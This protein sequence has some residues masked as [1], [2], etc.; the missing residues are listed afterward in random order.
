MIAK[1][2]LFPW[3]ENRGWLQ[4]FSYKGGEFWIIVSWLAFNEWALKTSSCSWWK[5]V[6]DR[7]RKKKIKK[8]S[9]EPGWLRAFQKETVISHNH[10]TDYSAVKHIQK[11]V[12]GIRGLYFTPFDNIIFENII[13]LLFNTVCRSLSKLTR[14]A[15]KN[16]YKSKEN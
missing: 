6:T 9:R 13:E 16:M 11:Q 7:E 1:P 12:D 2:L 14:L 10:A 15:S 5:D 8:I 3:Y 4:R